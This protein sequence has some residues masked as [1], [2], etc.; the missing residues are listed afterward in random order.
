MQSLEVIKDIHWVGALDY[1]LRIFDIIMYTPYGTTYNSY[2][3]KGNE[4]VAIFE[5][6]KV[7]FFDEYISRLNS[8]GVDINKIDYIVLDH[9]EPDHA[10]S[11][12]KLL[13]LSPKAKVVGSASAIRF[14]KEI[15]NKDFDSIIVNDNDTLSLGNKT[16]RF[17]SAPMLHWPDSMYTYVEEDK[18]LITCDSFGSHY[19]FEGVFDDLIP[20]EKEYMEALRYYFDC[21]MGP[22]KPYVLKALDKI[23][24][25][26][27]KTICPG[28][29]P[30]LR[31]NPHKIVNLYKEWSTPISPEI[32]GDKKVTISYVS[33]YGYTEELANT[34]ANGI[35][36]VGNFEVKLYNVIHND[37][38]N[39]LKDIGES[40]GILFGSPTIVGELLEPIRDLMSKLNPIVHGGKIAAGFGSFGWSG[41][42]VP[43]IETRLQ[44]LKMKL[45]GPGLK[46]NFKPSEDDLKAAFNFGIGFAETVLGKKSASYNPNSKTNIEE[47]KGGDGEIKLWKCLICG[48]IFEG[49]V[50]PE[51][52]PVCG[53]TSEQ[54]IQVENEVTEQVPTDETFVIIG[55]GAAGFYAA[56]TIRERNPKCSIKLISK[57]K[58]P[59]YFRPQL[60]DLLS[61]KMNETKFYIVSNE[62]YHK[63]RIEQLL[64][65]EVKSI[66]KDNKIILLGD[67][68]SINYDKLILANGSYNFIP[69]L[70]VTSNETE[71][72]TLSS[73][74]YKSI[75]GLF[76]IKDLNDVNEVNS[77]AENNKDIVVIGGGLLGLE[78]AWELKQKGNNVKVIEFLPRLLPRQLDIEGSEIFNNIISSSGVK[79]LT[80][81]SCSEIIVKNNSV[82][83]IKLESGEIIDCSI[84]L[85][86]V[87][88]RSNTKLALDNG[89]ECNKGIKVNEKMETNITDIY[90][91]G[92]VAELNDIVYG[93]WPAAV[94]MGKVAG[95]NATMASKNFKNFV[96]SLVFNALGADVFSAGTLDYNDE[97]LEEITSKDI[98]NKQYKKLFFKDNTLIGG[99][100]IGDLS[101]AGKII[102]ALD[103]KYSKSQCLASNIL[104]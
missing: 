38:N 31:S 88:V 15:A 37:V 93:N 16:L 101:N 34:I 77:F 43:R 94:E 50:V 90:A 47:I 28:H 5:T 18:T 4:K 8:L 56:K 6:V 21:I 14:M 52:C 1:G 46:I 2:V 22:F 59:S 74:N 25:L 79:I 57:E 20:N 35:K 103:K 76:T 61:E 33:A 24:D 42:A 84:V 39:I 96:S 36:S 78:A 32:N 72:M 49:E 75:N 70:K 83:A 91:C 82:K 11:V 98:K 55:N 102:A 13:E 7:Q 45:Y 99:I 41:E 40:D 30:V 53:A 97:S 62:W 12:A 87:G 64:G 60:S 71:L 92:D 17:I 29:G 81:K 3:V 44:E 68:T 100:L 85:F 65:V 26:E 54:F 58:V 23:K 69:P 89:I 10:G 80:S 63:N 48:E 19:C 104:A 67:G 73:F 51:I 86:S 95:A 66:N 27:I 9:T